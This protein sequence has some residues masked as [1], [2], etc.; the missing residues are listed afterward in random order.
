[1]YIRPKQLGNSSLP[2]E[3]LKTDRM[4]CQ[5][6]GP[7]GIGEKAIYL[8]SFYLDRR[9]YIPM[10][11]ITRIYK[12]IAMS[13]GG[14][15]KKGVFASM[16]Y[17]VVE[18]DHGQVKQ[19][20]FKFE[21]K[22]DELLD[23]VKTHFPQ[24]KTL[25]AKGE[26]IL[27]WEEAQREK[28]K[29]KNLTEQD[30][31]TM[32]EIIK[33]KEYLEEEPTLSTSLSYASKSMR[34]YNNTKPTYKWVALTILLGAFVVAAYGIYCVISRTGNIG[35]YCVLGGIGIV[36][37]VSASNILPTARNNRIALEKQLEKARAEMEK[38]IQSYE[39]FP[40]PARYA[41]PAALDRMYRSVEEGRADT[42]AEAYED[43]KAGLKALHSGVE[44]SQTEYDEVVA[45]KPMFLLEDY[46]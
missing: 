2:D 39:N 15:N 5:K 3:D 45:I 4:N 28:R 9:F 34:V 19:C 36:F 29:K 40:L 43:L 44:V 30:R 42:M 6:I 38:Y 41:H 37:L 18:Y 10:N 21:Q 23:Y 14:F 46:Q 17:L 22:V 16:P 35:I 1:M 24:I 8:N 33:A 32:A 25:S 26:E 11:T 27:A 7:C 20:N 12:R 31:E 13:K